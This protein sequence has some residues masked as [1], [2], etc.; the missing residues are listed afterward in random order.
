MNNCRQKQKTYDGEQYRKNCSW[1]VLFVSL[2]LAGFSM[3]AMA[4]FSI[5]GVVSETTGETIPGVSVAV[6]GTTQGTVTDIDGNFTIAVPNE[7]AVLVFSFVGYITQEIT[8]GDLREINMTMSEDSQQIQEV[9]VI[10]YGTSISKRDATGAISSVGEKVIEERTPINVFDALQ[11]SAPGLQI[12]SDGGSPGA[13]N[14]IMIRGAS[15]FSNDGVKPLFIVDGVIVNDI[16]NINP[17]DIKSMDILKDGASGAIYGARSANGVIIITTRQGEAGKPRVDVRVVHSFSWQANKIPQVNLG[18][19]PLNIN[20][21]RDAYPEKI[22][23][24]NDSVGLQRSTSIFYQEALMRVA[25]RLDANVTMSGGVDKIT[26]MASLGY[27]SDEGIMI[28]SYNNK[29]TGRMN[30]DFSASNRLKFISRF[31]FA[32]SNTNDIDETGIFFHGMRRPPWAMMQYPDGSFIPQSAW[33]NYRNPLQELIQQERLRTRYQAT[34]Y[35][36]GE[37]KFTDHLRLQANVMGNFDLGRRSQFR[38]GELENT[39]NA[40]NSGYD[41]TSWGTKYEGQVFMNY[42]RTFGNHG[43]TAMIGASAESAFSEEMRFEGTG[44]ASESGP[45]TF[46]LLETLS[47]TNTYTNATDYSMASVFGNASYNFKGK[48]QINGVIRRDGSSRFGKENRWGTFPSVS[49]YWRF[50]DEPFFEWTR[51]VLNDGKIRGSWG[52]LGNDRIGNYESQL[53]YQSSGFYN[54]AGAVMPVSTYGNPSVHWEETMATGGGIDLSFLGGRANMTIDYYYKKTTDLLADMSLPYTTGYNS[55]RMNL[56][57]LENKG[58]EFTV[59]GTPVRNKNFSWNTTVMWWTNKNKILDLAR[60]DYVA[61]SMWYV[62]KGKSAGQWY[63]RKHLGIYAYDISNAYTEDYSTLLTPVLE[64]DA[65][66]NVIFESGN[67]W[68]GDPNVLKYLLPDGTEYTGEIKKRKANGTTSTGGDVIWEAIPRTAE[69]NVDGVTETYQYYADDITDDDRQILGKATPDWYASWN[70]TVKYKQFTLSFNFYVSWGGQV[71]N[72]LKRQLTMWQGNTHMQDREYII[73][74]WKYQGQITDWYRVNNDGSGGRNY[75]VASSRYLE[76]GS[77]IRLRNARLSYQLDRKIAE[78]LHIK[79]L[80]AYVY[81][82]NLLT[83]TNYS[84]FDP[85]VGGGVLTPGEDNMRYPRKK[86]AGFGLN[87][88]F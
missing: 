54:G 70:N 12:T 44:F 61:S 38:S 78:K 40:P 82:T 52:V 41:R 56:A 3:S 31:S 73:T 83:W 6:K 32:Y 24:N 75:G 64:R 11:G 79:G 49:A 8:V 69:K 25:K 39:A 81:G 28:T 88:T 16:D 50:S 62:A 17:A 14:N 43:V 74:G 23:V 48:Y 85:E 10:G 30:V 77:F 60:E 4:Q 65:N 13:S 67:R 45:Y 66:G 18:E 58:W 80:T 34:L 72:S 33:S 37:F 86:E 22:A 15:T 47:L 26:Y 27:I 2:L 7:Q 36:G 55:M 19:E 5:R 87:V 59:S 71:Y 57:S 35:Q 76:D 84:G 46:N 68:V 51:G 63:G 42:A 20:G 53:R 9:V 1:R 29:F 21:R